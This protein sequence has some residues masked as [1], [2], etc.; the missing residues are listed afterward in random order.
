MKDL[1]GAFDLF[2]LDG[3]GTIGLE[4]IPSSFSTP[5]LNLDLNLI[6]NAEFGHR[7]RPTMH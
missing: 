1:K 6:G 5:H 4:A 2:D 7:T 3:S